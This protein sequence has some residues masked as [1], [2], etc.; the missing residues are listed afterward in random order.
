VRSRAT[1]PLLLAGA[2]QST[3]SAWAAGLGDIRVLSALGQ[4][5][6]AEIEL[7]SV[8]KG[9]QESLGA[10][11][12]SA[13]AYARANRDYSPSLQALRFEVVARGGGRYG[14]T[15]RSVV[16]VNDPILTVMVELSG[17]EGRLLREYTL[18]LDPPVAPAPQAAATPSTGAAPIAQQAFEPKPA[19]IDA[20]VE[21]G[22]I[23]YRVQAGDT[24]YRIAQDHPI[25]GVPVPAA[26]AII[27]RDNAAAFIN[28]D[29]NR[30]R[31]G[32]VLRIRGVATASNVDAT[33]TA[34]G[35][36]RLVAT[37]PATAVPRS[38]TGDAIDRALA[39]T[40]QQIERLEARIRKLQASLEAADAQI[41]ALQRANAVAEGAAAG[42]LVALE[43]IKAQAPARAPTASEARID[44]QQLAAAVA[45]GA[46]AGGIVALEVLQ[47]QASA[48]A[49]A[50]RG[51]TPA[52]SS[53]AAAAPVQTARSTSLVDLVLENIIVVA[54][55]LVALL[56]GLLGLLWY[57]GRGAKTPQD[58]AAAAD[59]VLAIDEAHSVMPMTDDPHTTGWPAKAMELLAEAQ[60][61]AGAFDPD[62]TQKIERQ[63]SA[64]DAAVD[65]GV[66]KP[67]AANT[68]DAVPELNEPLDLDRLL[69]I[70]EEKA[71]SADKA[72]QSGKPD[73]Q[74]DTPRKVA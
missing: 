13:D 49:S 32:S 23:N 46:E 42:G 41:E 14:L 34:P 28:G 50:S 8:G 38:E 60:E 36:P 44:A 26:A 2:L 45:D 71:Q 15:V 51:T 35:I 9:E 70:L 27:Q 53:A 17:S 65:A 7:L 74:G 54:G 63:V 19:R 69:D 61:P 57:R 47:A 43:A 20:A 18:F 16:P 24:L 5:F 37:P 40:E 22:A 31:A 21:S 3:S 55:A 12:A 39:Q 25:A 67:R 66:P 58:A 48:G 33:S 29:P 68:A 30:L 1:L 64:P 62:R 59:S 6:H 56:G 52:A 10:R 4:P 11:V 72:D 73:A